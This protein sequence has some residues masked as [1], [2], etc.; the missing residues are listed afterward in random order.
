MPTNNVVAGNYIGIN[1]SGIAFGNGG[2]GV[3]LNNA[4]GNTIGGAT[5]AAANVISGNGILTN[6]NGVSISGGGSNLVRG[7]R[8]GTNP[9]GTAAIPNSG[10]GVVLNNT[11]DN[12]IGGDAT[13]TRNLISGNGIAPNIGMGVNIFGTSTNN[14]I[15]GNYI[16][17]NV[18]GAGAIGNRT[19]GVFQSSG[20]ANRIGG[21]VGG[22]GNVIAA[23]GTNSN[24]IDIT[25]G[26]AII[27]GNSIGTNA[28][29]T[30][31]FPDSFNGIMLRTS[32]NTV[33][34]NGFARN[35]IS[36]HQIGVQIA[37]G[38]NSNTIVG[39]RIGTN[40]AGTSVVGI[41]NAQHGVLVQSANNTIGGQGGS[42]GNLISGN[43]LN[44]VLIASAAATGNVLLNNFIG[45]DAAGTS[46]IANGTGVRIQTGAANNVV[47]GAA[48]G[49][50][51]RIAFNT[52]NAIH[53]TTGVG[54]SFR[55][56][57]VFSNGGL[58]IDLEPNGPT[59]N[60]TNDPDSGPNNLQNYP[61]LSF[62]NTGGAV[63]GSLN[64]TPSTLFTLD[65]FAS[66]SC[67]PSGFGEGQRYLGSFQTSTGTNGT[68]MFQPNFGALTLGEFITATATDP[69]GN[70]SEFA[71]CVPV[72]AP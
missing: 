19:Y 62:A 55:G 22:E 28:T 46:P 1:A 45:T 39:N 43:A 4:V 33:G 66:A 69:N 2:S 40:P 42:L 60:D 25:G 34:G 29:G 7:N 53:V 3:A 59:P 41:G 30:A 72:A 26:T 61:V 56:N 36:G 58:G 17:T 6:N 68:A 64:S 65:V 50:G 20:T 11:N 44:G 32:G 24:Q 13:N 67:D 38:G 12:I 5:S 37:G 48:T 15:A 63:N 35:V 70:T 10:S 52:S 49:A 31:T 47:G 51:N 27:Q 21:S 16:G 8:I 57:A 18:T 23:N 9:A 14:Q 54:N 71:S